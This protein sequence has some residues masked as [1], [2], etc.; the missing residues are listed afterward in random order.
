MKMLQTKPAEEQEKP[1]LVNFTA[2]HH[3]DRLLELL[4]RI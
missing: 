3:I 1:E 2:S 4:G